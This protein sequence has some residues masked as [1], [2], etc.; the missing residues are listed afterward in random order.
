MSEKEKQ[1]F[2]F[3]RWQRLLRRETIRDFLPWMAYDPK[4][5]LFLMEG[6][7][8]GACY[9]ANIL[10]GCDSSTVAEFQ[11]A[12]S[13]DMPAGTIVQFLQANV[14]DVSR[15]VRAFS[16][17][18]EPIEV[19]EELDGNQRSALAGAS[20]KTLAHL[21]RMSREGAFGDSHVVFS[22]ARLLVS[23]KMSASEVPTASQIA[24][25]QDRLNAFEGALQ[26]LG[27]KRLGD[28]EFLA[29]LRRLFHIDRHDD[30]RVLEDALLRDQVLYAGDALHVIPGG[31]VLSTGEG[32]RHVQVLSTRFFPKRMG[33]DIMNAVIGDPFGVRTQFTMPFAI[34]LT[35][36]IPDQVDERRSLDR[37]YA[38]V[39]Y[40]AQGP[41]I[42]WV[43]K[44]GLRKQGYD[45]LMSALDQG[46]RALQV[47]M[48][49]IMWCPDQKS[50][51]LS[52]SLI[53]GYLGSLGFTVA[54]DRFLGAVQ[55]LN[56]LP[57]LPSQ[58]SLTMT[59]RTQHMSSSQATQVLPAL[60]DWLGQ[61]AGPHLN[62]V[63]ETGAGTML[64]SR[65]GHPVWV[66][67]FAT[68]GNYNFI[69]AGDSGSGKTF[70]A[71]QVVL[72][73]LESGGQAWVIEIGRGF[74]KMCSMIGGDHIRMNDTSDFG[75]NPFTSVR[76]IDE[77][78][79]ELSAIFGAMIDPSP[80]VTFRAG[81]TPEDM[82]IVKEAVRAVWGSRSNEGTP[83]DVAN[84]LYRQEGNP[85]AQAMAR[86]MGEFTRNGAYG[87]WFNRPMDVNL[88][89]R[90]V[91]LE[92]GELSSRKHLQIV[93]LLQFMFAIQRT[94][95]DRAP[96]DS[97][98]RMLF[99][100]EASE[101]LKIKAAAEFMEGAARR[102][103]K[104]RGS[105]GI[106]IQRVDDLYLSEYTK[107]I[108]SQAESYY[109][110]KQR[111]ETVHAIEKEGRLSLDE[112]GYTMLRSVRRTAE[113]SE[114]MVYQ[115]GNYVVGRLSVDP[116][117]RVL[118]SSSGAERDA[119][120]NLIGRGVPVGQAI[121]TYLKAAQDSHQQ[122]VA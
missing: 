67:P 15:H 45:V 44:L 84:Y 14:P 40:Q 22:D 90:F 49:F 13:Q 80:D 110:L 57:L 42:R 21:Q 7:Y 8:L 43:P 26:A 77:E 81:L 55:F 66:D 2:L 3:E 93:V 121:E 82:S 54:V 63:C 113:Y 105:I 76:D 106:G 98:R 10:S 102:V 46:D 118:F 48:C 35:I 72:D 33:L 1:S 52:P 94:I 32:E 86:M 114:V 19:D 29:V 4:S 91:V 71:N 120:L 24:T 5:K 41:L 28:A 16:K 65:R 85:R 34:S 112:W 111:A 50:A 38:A 53:Q 117:R 56:S 97:R 89:G 101:L 99:V 73:H 31:C 69:I 23:V 61:I 9:E 11:A 107:I 74:E 116:F 96:L 75:L 47:G 30:E 25:V 51:S 104:S 39:N 37:Q 12:L 122:E 60:G 59:N 20:K 17:A 92:L 79:D 36:V 109:L 78:I 27:L 119:I 103:R 58:D 87:H 18:R 62:P 83:D 6:G 70:F 64:V 88:Q 100:D 108:A 68:T 95:Q 115:G